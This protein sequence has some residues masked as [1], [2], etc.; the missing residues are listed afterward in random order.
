[1]GF[2]FKEFCFAS[3]VL[4]YLIHYVTP[5]LF[6]KKNSVQKKLGNVREMDVNQ[7]KTKKIDQNKKNS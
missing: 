2:S 7:S 4:V 6:G 3:T 5:L 1:M